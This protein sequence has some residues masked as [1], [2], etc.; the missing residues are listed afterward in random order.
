MRK[1]V[2]NAELT[3]DRMGSGSLCIPEWD[4]EMN[5]ETS[6]EKESENISLEVEI[7]DFS[8]EEF[9]KEGIH[10]NMNAN[11]T[12]YGANLLCYINGTVIAEVFQES[13]TIFVSWEELSKLLHIDVR[14]M[15]YGGKGSGT[16]RIPEWDIEMEL[17]DVEND[18]EDMSADVDIPDYNSEEFHNEGIHIILENKGGNALLDCSLND[19]KFIEDCKENDT[20]FVSWEELSRL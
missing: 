8:S 9:H 14:L 1:F 19:I 2:I 20:I 7:P 5:L 15:L 18:W 12:G 10:I 11:G 16:L 6:N 13:D 4:I 3:V 17:I